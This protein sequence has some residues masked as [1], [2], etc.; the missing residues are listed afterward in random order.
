[1]VSPPRITVSKTY[2][3]FCPIYNPTISQPFFLRQTALSNETLTPDY[4]QLMYR[5]LGVKVDPSSRSPSLVPVCV[6]DV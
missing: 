6:K 5:S 1:M 3:P 4:R 2:Q